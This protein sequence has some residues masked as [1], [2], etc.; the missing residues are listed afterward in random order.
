MS[1]VLDQML[2]VKLDH[3]KADQR[4]R[5]KERH[6][7]MLNG[8]ILK[9]ISGERLTAEQGRWIFYD[10]I[11]NARALRMNPMTGNSNTFFRLGVQAWAREMLDRAKDL[12]IGLVHKMELEA[13]V[14][15][16]QEEQ[17]EE[18]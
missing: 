8:L 13:L 15:A 14:R 3:K 5:I 10:L 18:R 2:E 4:I 11:A 6:E 12:N 17:N 7:Q 16:Q 1:S 9:L